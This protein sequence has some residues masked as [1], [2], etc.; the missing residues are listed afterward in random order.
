MV[1]FR[2]DDPDPDKR[3]EDMGYYMDRNKQ[4]MEVLSPSELEVGTG[5][6]IVLLHEHFLLKYN[7]IQDS[8]RIKEDMIVCSQFRDVQE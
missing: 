6:K 3:F 8:E 1:N 7:E 5:M 2:L 4:F